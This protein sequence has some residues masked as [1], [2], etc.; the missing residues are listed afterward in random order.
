MFEPS[1]GPP[2]AL[3]QSQWWVRLASFVP[4]DRDAGGFNREPRLATAQ[5][6]GNATK[7]GFRMNVRRPLLLVALQTVMKVWG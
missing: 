5:E 1:D 6:R 3:Y 2:P 4:E 7:Q